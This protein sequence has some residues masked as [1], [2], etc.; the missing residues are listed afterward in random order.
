MGFLYKIDM[1]V[2]R[3][4]CSSRDYHY[5]NEEGLMT[6]MPDLGSHC[7]YKTVMRLSYI[8]NVNTYTGM[9]VC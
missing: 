7:K 8:D 5:E 4:T 9:I 1:A 3:P 6:I 2:M